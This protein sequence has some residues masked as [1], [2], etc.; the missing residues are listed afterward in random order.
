MIG[1]HVMT[2]KAT[3]AD[4]DAV[5]EYSIEQKYRPYLS[6]NKVRSII[7]YTLILVVIIKSA[8]QCMYY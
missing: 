8:I 2:V 7:C 1:S 4:V 5:L 6:I 3:D